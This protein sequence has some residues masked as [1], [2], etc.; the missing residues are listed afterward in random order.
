MTT[1][2]NQTNLSN[3]TFQTQQQYYM[4]KNSPGNKFEQDVTTDRTTWL[5]VKSYIAGTQASHP[6]VLYPRKVRN[7][8]D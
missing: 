2:N 6:A 7:R 1:H 5:P 8:P 3:Y 4:V